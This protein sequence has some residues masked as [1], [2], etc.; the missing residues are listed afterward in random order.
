M[1]QVDQGTPA[2]RAGLRAGTRP[3][4]ARTRRVSLGG[5]I[6]TAI[7]N[8]PLKRPEDL[9]VYLETQKSASDSVTLTVVRD[10]Q[11]LNLTVQLGERPLR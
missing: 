6:L 10:A 11:T 1:A 7:D 8:Q 3:A 9:T 2:A 5:D 4:D